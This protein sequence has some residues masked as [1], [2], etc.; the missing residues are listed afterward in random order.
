MHSSDAGKFD[1]SSFFAVS[2]GGKGQIHAV[3]R[4]LSVV[5]KAVPGGAAAVAAKLGNAVPRDVCDVHGALVGEAVNDDGAGV[6]C[7]DGVGHDANVFHVSVP[8]GRLS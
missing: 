6:V 4:G 8:I 2:V 5:E 1:H 7:A 3:R